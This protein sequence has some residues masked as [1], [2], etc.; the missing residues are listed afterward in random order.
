MKVYNYHSR[1][2][3]QPKEVITKLFES[4][5]TENDKIWPIENWPAMRFKE[6]LKIGS[7]GGHGPIRYKII[8]HK[9]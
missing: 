2:Y 7:R 6:G 5:T 3:N 1:T 8:E 4:L 9:P